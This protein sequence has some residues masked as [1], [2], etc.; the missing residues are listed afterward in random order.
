MVPA[1]GVESDI[2]PRIN[3]WGSSG[4]FPL[5]KPETIAPR[6][7]SLVLE[8]S[9]PQLRLDSAQGLRPNDTCPYFRI[10]F[11]TRC[12]RSSITGQKKFLDFTRGTRKTFVFEPRN[13]SYLIKEHYDGIIQERTCFSFGMWYL[14]IP[15]TNEFVGFLERTACENYQ[16][17]RHEQEYKR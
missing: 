12:S 9:V 4:V 6:N 7:C 13:H 14:S 10:V 17:Y 16:L 15:P 8:V 3:S 1:G 11:G 2:L 5:G